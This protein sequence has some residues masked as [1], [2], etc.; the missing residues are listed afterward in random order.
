M[1]APLKYIRI[2]LYIHIKYIFTKNEEKWIYVFEMQQFAN[3][4]KLSVKRLT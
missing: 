1:T 3:Y 2:D 4:K